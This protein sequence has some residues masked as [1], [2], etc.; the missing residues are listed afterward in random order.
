MKH[1]LTV[2]KTVNEQISGRVICQLHETALISTFSL[3]ISI[4]NC[5]HF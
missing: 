1:F 5:C 4:F 3:V 2:D